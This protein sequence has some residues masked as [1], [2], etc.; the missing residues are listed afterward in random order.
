MEAFGEIHKRLSEAFNNLPDDDRRKAHLGYILAQ[1]TTIVQMRIN[2]KE[3]LKA[4]DRKLF[5]WQ[6]NVERSIEETLRD[7]SN[8]RKD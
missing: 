1:H 3:A 6:K 2:N 5:D 4:Y 8:Q 7:F